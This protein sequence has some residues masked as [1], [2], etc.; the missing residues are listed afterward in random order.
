[1]GACKADHERVPGR[2]PEDPQ[3]R[4]MKAEGVVGRG[5]LER[6]RPQE[7]ARTSTAGQRCEW[8]VPGTH[9]LRSSVETGVIHTQ[10]PCQA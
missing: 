3:E 1:M 2:H 5:R 10:T 7:E 4:L 8:G 6:A 9:R